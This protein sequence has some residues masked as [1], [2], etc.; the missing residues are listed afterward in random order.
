MII[1]DTCRNYLQELQP[2]ATNYAIRKNELRHIIAT[3]FLNYDR[4][5]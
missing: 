5:H 2:V 4:Y 1:S 3:L